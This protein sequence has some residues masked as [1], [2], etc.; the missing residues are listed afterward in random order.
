MARGKMWIRLGGVR[1]RASARNPDL[2]IRCRGSSR[3]RG[4]LEGLSGLWGPRGRGGESTVEE[5]GYG[6]A[7]EPKSSFAS[8]LGTENVYVLSS[9]CLNEKVSGGGEEGG[10]SDLGFS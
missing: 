4:I 1:A 6:S 3:G 8:V 7:E 9:L 10:A 5:A 2:R